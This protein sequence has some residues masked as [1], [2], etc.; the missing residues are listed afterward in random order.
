M[1][2]P[3]HSVIL[4]IEEV[5]TLAKTVLVAQFQEPEPAIS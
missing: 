3:G 2:V 5:N 1:W 4:G